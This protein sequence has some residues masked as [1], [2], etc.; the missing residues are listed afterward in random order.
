MLDLLK[1]LI[2]TRDQMTSY[3][4]SG[5]KIVGGALA[6]H[7]VAVSPDVWSAVSGDAAIQV[8]TGIAM[9]IVPV[10]VDTFLHSDAGKLKAAAT[11]ATGPDPQIKPIQA[12]PSAAP[13][14]VALARDTTVPGVQ[15]AS[16]TY[17]PPPSP[18]Q[19]R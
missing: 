19:R 7:G 12:L 1:L 8:Y 9:A 5:F 3:I 15:P 6:T 4:R 2:P 16:T 17:S 14:I 18:T 10:I 13:G 11:L